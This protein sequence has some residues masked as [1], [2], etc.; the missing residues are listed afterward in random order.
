MNQLR[1][2]KY[3]LYPTKDQEQILAQFFG[4]K[5]WV[6]NHFL[7]E[8]K[9]RFANKE[10]HLNNYDINVQI[11]QLKKQPETA[12]LRE[13]DDWCLKHAAVDLHTAYQNFFKSITGKRKGPKLQVP[14]YMSKDS[15]QSYRTRGVKVDIENSTVK[16]PKIK[17]VKVVIHR[18]FI[19]TIKS[20]TISKNPDGQYYISVLVEEDIKSLPSTK[21]EIGID[22]GIKDLLILSN[23]V[24]FQHPKKMLEK[25]NLALKKQQKKLARK[26][27]SSNNRAK[28]RTKVARAYA[29]ISRIRNNYYHEISTYL[30]RNFDAIYMENLNVK[31][32]LQNRKLSRAIHEAS[33]S[34]LVSMISYKCNFYARPFHQI[35]R[36][37]ASSKTCSC[38]GHEL[39]KLDLG[40]R[41]WT[42]PSCGAQHDRDINAAINIKNLGQI[43]LYDQ[44][45][46][47]GATTEVGSSIPKALVKW[48]TKTER[49]P[50]VFGVSPG[51]EQA[52]RS[53]D[54]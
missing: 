45:I 19:G 21:T 41:D 44:L 24:K 12:W 42:C 11:T 38:C 8:N 50:S 23:G 29:R 47:S 26:T 33:W 3:R 20:A 18:K 36:F 22:L 7:H 30:V 25:A 52:R 49:S 46:P 1:A 13:I 35:D 54:V 4:A 37:A 6:F 40:T 15:R 48:T 2:Y 16:L 51:T 34:T 5:R 9:Q 32:I 17:N 10:K 28:Q 39:E 14:K 53:L 31:S 43:D 27:K